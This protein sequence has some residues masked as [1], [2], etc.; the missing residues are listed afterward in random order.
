MSNSILKENTKAAFSL[1]QSAKAKLQV[2]VNRLAS[3][4]IAESG[5]TVSRAKPHSL[6]KQLV[7]AFSRS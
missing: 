5:K 3:E 7:K 2:L 1:P 4:K 6:R